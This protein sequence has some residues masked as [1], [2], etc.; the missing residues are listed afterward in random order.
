MEKSTIHEIKEYVK[1]IIMKRTTKMKLFRGMSLILCIIMMMQLTQLF[2]FAVGEDPPAAETNGEATPIDNTLS[3]NLFE[4]GEGE[5]P[6][7]Q[8]HRTSGIPR[9]L[10]R[11]RLHPV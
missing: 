10:H 4:L 3:E 9:Q 7:A 2:V 6:Y 11:R 8:L 1:E 5:L